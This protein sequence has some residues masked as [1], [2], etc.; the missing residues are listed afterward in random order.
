L[1][2]YQGRIKAENPDKAAM[3]IREKY[4]EYEG[5]LSIKWLPLDNQYEYSIEVRDNG[6]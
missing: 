1:K 4:N 3:L 5:K 2:F 6:D